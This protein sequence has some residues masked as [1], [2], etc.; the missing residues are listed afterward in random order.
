MNRQIV[1]DIALSQVGYLEKKSNADLDDKT[2]N[3]GNGNYT[4]YA[5]DID[6][7]PGYFN[8]KKQGQAWCAT[9]VNDCFVKAYGVVEAKKLLCQPMNS[10][11]ASCTYAMSYFKQAGRFKSVPEVGAQI[12]FSW[13]HTGIV[14][15]VDST[16]VYTV[17]GNTRANGYEGVWEKSY[18]RDYVNILGYGCPNYDDDEPV[19]PDD[20]DEPGE[21]SLPVIK[22]GDESETVKA[23]QILLEGYGYSVGKWG[24]DGEYGNDTGKALKSYQNA[25]GLVADGECGDRT[26]SKLLGLEG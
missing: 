15:K 21:L 10:L 1:V 2:A 16:K 5:R 24:C 19:D 25:H 26:W 3:A 23:M 7:I 12:F 20:P 8:G 17:E 13:G 18:N 4:K 11:A 6:A 22:Y 9:F 14:V